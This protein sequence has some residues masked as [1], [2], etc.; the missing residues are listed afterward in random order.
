MNYES[1]K[2]VSDKKEV[3]LSYLYNQLLTEKLTFGEN[4]LICKILKEIAIR[5]DIEIP[6]LVICTNI[7]VDLEKKEPRENFKI[8]LT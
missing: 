1:K 3:T 8:E 4:V 5:E 2:L 6:N 7:F